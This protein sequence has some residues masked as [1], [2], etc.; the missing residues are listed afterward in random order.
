M[1]S[2]S[3]AFHQ[4]LERPGITAF[5]K[6]KNH[7]KLRKFI[8]TH[9][10]LSADEITTDMLLTYI[11]AQKGRKKPEAAE[12]T[13]AMIGDCFHALFKYCGLDQNP[14]DGLPEWKDYPRRIIIPDE[15]A[16]K[17]AFD[18]AVSMCVHG[19]AALTRDGLIFA[20]CL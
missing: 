9:G 11:N 2:L 19:E 13:K 3:N 6:S 7:Y 10:H 4:W 18:E 1:T 16:V 8:R 17:R 14:A 20:L 12:A 15:T 5:T